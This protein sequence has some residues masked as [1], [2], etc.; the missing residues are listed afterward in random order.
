M[1]S[2][3]IILC[4]FF[5]IC[6]SH[7]SFPHRIEGEI[8]PVLERMEVILG[9]IETGDKELA[10]REAQEVF[11]D[12]H[13]HDFSRVEEGLKTIAVRMDREFGTNLEKQLE[14]SFSKKDPELLG[15]T[16]KTLGLLLMIERFKFVESKL[17][18]FS[19]SELK[20][21]KKHF[22]RGRNYF[23]ILFEPVLAKHDPAEEVR[24]ERLL[25]KMLYSLE[26]RKLKDFYRARIELVE[27]IT[28]DFGLS[29]P[30]TLLNEKQ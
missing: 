13:Y 7:P 22:W 3:Y 11:E 24:L 19:K 27:R 18:S 2:I 4:L 16:I 20:D 14:D 29:L 26:D 21:L 10:F 5:V 6:F 28:R 23:T 1:R 17:G 12:F 9:L 15:K 25:D 8:T 30:T